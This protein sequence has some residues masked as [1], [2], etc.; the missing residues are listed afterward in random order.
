M[1]ILNILFLGTSGAGVTINRNLPAI[2]IDRSILVDCG[3]G[4]L[5]SLLANGVDPFDIQAIFL[6]HLHAD[7]C[8]GIIPL[9]WNLAFYNL[10]KKKVSPPI[11]VPEGMASHLKNIV[12]D[13]FSP[14]ERIGFSIN[15]I[16]LP[17]SQNNK[18]NKINFNE[19]YHIS[20]IKTE[21][22]PIC[23]AY[24]F[25]N[26]VVFGADTQPFPEFNSFV[27]N[28]DTL[29]FEATFPDSQAE[30]AHKLKHS[31]PLDAAN[32]GS[33]IKLKRI[34]LTHVPDLNSLQ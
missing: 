31:T 7:H 3:E 18:S 24:K 5:K 6:T 28:C 14:F 2:L 17:I 22:T 30:L 9:L 33:Q 1:D 19:K 8:L 23:Y 15:I 34:I 4:C 27:D 29:I 26:S 21:H 11:Y 13:S 16:E 10:R 25:N 20:W 12:Q 32:I